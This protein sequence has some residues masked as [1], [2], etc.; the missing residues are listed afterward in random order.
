MKGLL[1]VIKGAGVASALLLVPVS[2]VAGSSHTHGHSH[3]AAKLP[4]TVHGDLAQAIQ[5]QHEHDFL[6]ARQLLNHYLDHH[7][8]DAQALL[9]LSAV[10]AATGHWQAARSSCAPLSTQMPDWAV[11]ACL[12]QVASGEQE[13]QATLQLLANIPGDRRDATAEWARDIAHELQ[14]RIEHEQWQPFAPHAALTHTQ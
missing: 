13:V 14:H 6:T 2:A 4:S 8:G 9:V 11:A 5:A 10:E 1:N 3:G 12:G 7:P